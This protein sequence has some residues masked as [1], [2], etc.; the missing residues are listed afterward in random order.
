MFLFVFCSAN[1]ALLFDALVH[2]LAGNGDHL[3]DLKKGC[4]TEYHHVTWPEY[5]S[6]LNKAKRIVVFIKDLPL[7]Q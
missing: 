1:N 4:K 2:I 5:L 7:G 6:M 3:I